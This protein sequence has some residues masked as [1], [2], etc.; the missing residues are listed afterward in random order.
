MRYITRDERPWTI[1]PRTPVRHVHAANTM[2]YG[3]GGA[4]E[5]PDSLLQH[6][7]QRK[8]TAHI[9]K[10]SRPVLV[11]SRLGWY[12][13]ISDMEFQERGPGSWRRG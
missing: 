4:Q 8:K 3:V 1:G 5:L 6:Q 11:K 10:I 9:C 12:Q 2:A 13:V 7:R